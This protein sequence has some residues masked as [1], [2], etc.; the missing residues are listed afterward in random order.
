MVLGT[1]AAD[2]MDYSNLSGVKRGAGGEGSA[3]GGTEP[4]G[5]RPPKFGKGANGKQGKQGKGEGKGTGR[6][7]RG[8]GSGSGNPQA[9]TPG[10]GANAVP[11]GGN[12]GPR[13]NS[14]LSFSQLGKG[15]VEDRVANLEKV[16]GALGR[17][18]IDLN[19]DR[20]AR[21]QADNVVFSRQL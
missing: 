21:D 18:T 14:N 19:N 3:P 15:K 11:A 2:R 17:L 12:G 4:F 9:G 8:R 6:G 10:T 1:P 20:R 16:I 13:N 5:A 7:S